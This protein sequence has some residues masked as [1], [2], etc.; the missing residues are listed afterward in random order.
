MQEEVSESY[1]ALVKQALNACLAIEQEHKNPLKG[2]HIQ[3]HKASNAKEARSALAEMLCSSSLV[4]QYLDDRSLKIIDAI[5][6][7]EMQKFKKIQD[8]TDVPSLSKVAGTRIALWRGDITALGVDAV[9]NCASH[10]KMLGC[11]QPG[12]PCLDNVMHQAAGPR[13]RL[14]I[15]RGQHISIET[16][17][18][19]DGKPV[20]VHAHKNADNAS[21]LEPANVRLTPGFSLPSQFIVHVRPPLAAPRSA[22]EDNAAAN[23][24]C[25]NE[26]G[27]CY[28]ACLDVCKALYD[29][30]Q[31][32]DVESRLSGKRFT[33][34]EKPVA[35]RSIAFPCIGTGNFGFTSKAAAKIALGTVRRWLSREENAGVLD[36]VVFTV[37]MAIDDA[38]YSHLGPVYFPPRG[39]GLSRSDSFGSVG[40]IASLDVGVLSQEAEEEEQMLVL[41]DD[42]GSE[43]DSLV[44]KIISHAEHGQAQRVYS[45]AHYPYQMGLVSSYSQEIARAELAAERLRSLPSSP[46]KESPAAGAGTRS[47][48]VPS[49]P[50]PAF[51][52]ESASVPS[53]ETKLWADTESIDS[54]ADAASAEAEEEDSF[55]QYDQRGRELEINYDDVYTDSTPSKEVASKEYEQ[56]IEEQEEDVWNDTAI[57]EGKEGDEEEEK[58]GGSDMENWGGHESESDE[59]NH[60]TTLHKEDVYVPPPAPAPAPPARR[61]SDI[62][63]EVVAALP[64]FPPPPARRQS[65]IDREAAA[66]PASAPAPAASV[67][68][69]Q[70]QQQ[71]MMMM[72]AASRRAEAQNKA[73]PAIA[74]GP[75]VRRQSDMDREAVA[76]LP[77]SPAPPARRQS[78][79]DRE[80][81]AATIPTPTL[82][83]A[84]APVAKPEPE[85]HSVSPQL[86]LS[87]NLFGIVAAPSPAISISPLARRQSIMP[88][89]KAMPSLSPTTSVARRQ[90]V[91]MSSSASVPTPTRAR[92]QSVMRAPAPTVPRVFFSQAE[93]TV[94]PKLPEVKLKNSQAMAAEAPMVSVDKSKKFFSTPDVEALLASQ[95]N[96]C[97]ELL[98]QVKDDFARQLKG[99]TSLKAAESTLQNAVA[100]ATANTEKSMREDHDRAMAARALYEQEL[101]NRDSES[102]QELSELQNNLEEMEEAQHKWQKMCGQ[103]ENEL[104]E[105]VEA[106]A[107]AD[108][109]Y[110]E[111]EA[112]LL[113]QCEAALA[114]STHH[115]E[116]VGNQTQSQYSM[117]IAKHEAELK[118]ANKKLKQCQADNESATAAE[119]TK[120]EAD[121]KAVHKKLAQ[122]QAEMESAAVSHQKKLFEALAQ[123]REALEAAVLE[124]QNRADSAYNEMY[125]TL[126]HDKENLS[127]QKEELDAKLLEQDTWYREELARTANDGGLAVSALEAAHETQLASY[128]ADCKAAVAAEHERQQ[129]LLKDFHEREVKE[130]VERFEQ[131]LVTAKEDQEILKQAVEHE[132]ERSERHVQ[133][134]KTRYNLL[135]EKTSKLAAQQQ[136]ML[137]IQHAAADEH[138]AYGSALVAE[139]AIKYAKLVTEHDLELDRVK[140]R[141]DQK[142]LRMLAENEAAMT[143]M[144]KLF[145]KEEQDHAA[146]QEKQRVEAAE[147]LKLVQDRFNRR[148]MAV[149]A[150]HD[151]NTRE[152]A[153]EF[154]SKYASM[155]EDHAIL[156]DRSVEE[157][158]ARCDRQLRD[159]ADKFNALNTAHDALL[160]AHQTEVTRQLDP[161]RARLH[162]QSTAHTRAM[163]TQRADHELQLLRLQEEMEDE[164]ALKQQ[165]FDERYAAL[166]ANIHILERKAENSAT[167]TSTALKLV[168][169]EQ[170][171]AAQ[172]SLTAKH[173]ELERSRVEIAAL[174]KLHDELEEAQIAETQRQIEPLKAR[175]QEQHM[176][177]QRQMKSLKESHELFVLNLTEDWEEAQQ[178]ESQATEE[179][180]EQLRKDMNADFSK[181]AAKISADALINQKQAL[182][183]QQL[184][185]ESKLMHVSNEHEDALRTL[186]FA[187]EK[188]MLEHQTNANKE[189]T[190]LQATMDLKISEYEQKLHK[191]ELATAAA[192]AHGENARAVAEEKSGTD[193]REQAS[194][195]EDA[196]NRL[197]ANHEKAIRAEQAA[198]REQATIAETAFGRARIEYEQ[199]LAKITFELQDQASTAEDILQ[200]L[201]VDHEKA[202][203]KCAFDLREAAAAA[204]D[205]QERLRVDHEK[206]IRAEQAT[207]FRNKAQA[208]DALDAQKRISEETIMT[209][210]EN[211]EYRLEVAAAEAA[212]AS[213]A[214]VRTHSSE[215]SALQLAVDNAKRATAAELEDASLAFQA[216]HLKQ[217]SEYEL[218]ASNAK[219]AAS[220]EL[221]ETKMALEAQ[222]RDQQTELEQAVVL[223][224]QEAKLLVTAAVES[225]RKSHSAAVV[226]LEQ[227]IKAL[228]LQLA[229][230]VEG[231]ATQLSQKKQEIDRANERF[232]RENSAAVEALRE[233]LKLANEE[234]EEELSHQKQ[235]LDRTVE[236]LNRV[237]MSQVTDLKTQLANAIEERDEELA[238]HKHDAERAWEHVERM[239]AATVTDLKQ[240]L[241]DAL[242]DGAQELS[243]LQEHRDQ[244]IEE[245]KKEITRIKNAEILKLTVKLRVMQSE[246]DAAQLKMEDEHKEIVEDM[247]DKHRDDLRA[248]HEHNDQHLL[249]VIAPQMRQ[250]QMDALEAQA[251]VMEMRLRL[252]ATPAKS[253]AESNQSDT[254]TP[255]NT[256]IDALASRGTPG[257]PATPARKDDGAVNENDQ[258]WRLKLE[259]AAKKHESEIA[260]YEEK[261]RN[262]QIA[263]G[264]EHQIMSSRLQRKLARQERNLRNIKSQL[265]NYVPPPSPDML[266]KSGTPLKA[267]KVPLQEKFMLPEAADEEP[268]LEEE[269]EEEAQ[270]ADNEG[271][272][273]QNSGLFPETP[274]AGSTSFSSIRKEQAGPSAIHS[275]S[276]ELVVKPSAVRGVQI[277]SDIKTEIANLRRENWSARAALLLQKQELEDSRR[278]TASADTAYKRARNLAIKFVHRR[279]ID[280]KIAEYCSKIQRHWRDVRHWMPTLN[281]KE[282]AAA[283]A[284]YKEK[285]AKAAVTPAKVNEPFE[286]TYS[287]A[288]LQKAFE[289]SFDKIGLEPGTAIPSN[290]SKSK[291]QASSQL[292]GVEAE[293]NTGLSAAAQRAQMQAEI[294]A[295]VQAQ[296]K[297]LVDSAALSPAKTE[298]A[299]KAERAL[300]EQTNAATQESREAEALVVE[301]ARQAEEARLSELAA[302]QREADEERRLEEQAR[303]AEE[304]RAHLASQQLVVKM[305]QR[306]IA[307]EARIAERARLAEMSPMID[308]ASVVHETRRASGKTPIETQEEEDADAD[309]EEFQLNEHHIADHDRLQE[310]LLQHEEQHEAKLEK[311]ADEVRLSQQSSNKYVHHAQ[312]E[313]DSD[314]DSSVSSLGENNSSTRESSGKPAPPVLVSP[315]HG[316]HFEQYEDSRILDD[317]D[318]TDL[319]TD[320]H[321]NFR[322]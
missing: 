222:L 21:L 316:T 38:L 189:R 155:A 218:A 126:T 154:E 201:S 55:G 143:E 195:A 54:G 20:S 114:E 124:T 300:V 321:A 305:E 236:H 80:A 72:E 125:H 147:A 96:Q 278:Q 284:E 231:Q 232:I 161:L 261:I 156:L 134:E 68:Q 279:A 262:A 168:M 185:Y 14:S 271:Q 314:D 29:A 90:S 214:L 27:R 145:E 296:I 302:A 228:E 184:Q 252:A 119:M 312:K 16:G 22:C 286:M 83:A 183:A 315:H 255:F 64:G 13:L 53:S 116:E 216:Q 39:L 268:D 87:A 141:A 51:L 59:E 190:M 269:E 281:E 309:S 172:K 174:Q 120:H 318:I 180:L 294:Q 220:V 30:A 259:L 235:T 163:E 130:V 127:R 197:R 109:A 307:E 247:E 238:Q 91:M 233:Q 205:A 170:H 254:L 75:P 31:R 249:D 8:A 69:A 1:P 61:Q 250:L 257:S 199:S 150:E 6:R 25:V 311:K 265:D 226:E 60:I 225:A 229:G 219:R 19:D 242:E 10:A 187:L 301:E 95:R 92:R 28:E 3:S 105:V 94:L 322:A 44:G 298:E 82:A 248:V 192:V 149:L 81:L 217:R 320:E 289:A 129:A 208:A 56:F 258:Y 106:Q 24:E 166:Q 35:I 40:S 111:R 18:P 50:T 9:V 74:P 230:T 103:L 66:E 175:I 140:S 253:A 133:H 36:L 15:Q 76:A 264:Q 204:E 292:F 256:A 47:S 176:K 177:H 151:R 139:Q 122:S 173:D 89:M 5:L 85:S 117:L 158:R 7:Y 52:K 191:A 63:R 144:R 17:M 110:R 101:L 102:S 179:K 280:R 71:Q 159:A 290:L 77:G 283:A 43:S 200:R 215:V 65:A 209:A 167:E 245:N 23:Q 304:E 272:S 274:A 86:S 267:L 148:H 241:H 288:P 308:E 84:S 49:S 299:K 251:Q 287:K 112:D 152:R 99:C 240:K 212:H 181:Q 2:K 186:R 276:T 310:L 303:A 136:E 121:L 12:H 26:L 4:S 42:D 123:G 137:D 273:N 37:F 223:A 45:S 162:E 104:Q 275:I 41:H 153:A 266:V 11:Y 306:R 317:V 93:K 206:A 297:A 135:A 246:T 118:V 319:Q 108:A 227:Q 282:K 202:L 188:Q 33:K 113:K 165:S 98:R 277:F 196:L 239:H 70:K 210:K 57:P 313:R 243:S 73:S 178:R 100:E 221:A 203:A 164:A 88:S 171:E 142:H 48:D 115:L 32:Q 295:Q 169:Q 34:A 67:Q 244:T 160:N 128:R 146:A 285:V 182:G 58:E 107:H 213:A 194:A 79:I 207:T 138:E 198:M 193:L 270:G 263:V 78:A 132:R 62:D 97:T 293:A 157:I 291:K 234:K 237:H 131:A 260:R 46:D 211:F 224:K